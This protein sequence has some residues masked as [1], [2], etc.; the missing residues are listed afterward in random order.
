MAARI[1]AQA[2]KT[3]ARALR[4]RGRRRTE[5]AAQPIF[6]SGARPVLK[7]P[8]VEP[9]LQLLIL[10][11]GPA[12]VLLAGAAVQLSVGRWLRRPG[13]LTGAALFFVAVAG[14]LWL[15]LRFTPDVPVYST[16]WR[17]LLQ[18]GGANLIWIGDGWNWYVSG[19]ILLLGALGILLELN[20]RRSAGRQRRIHAALAVHL[21]VLAG[22]LLFVG[23]ANL[24]TVT[25]TW[26]VLD[27]ISLVR[28]A[29]RG[30]SPGDDS[31]YARG[32]SL[33]GALLLLVALLPAGPTGP[34][35]P[36]QGGS[37]PP[38]SIV[39]LLLAAMIRAGVY[40]FHIWLLPTNRTRVDLAERLLDHMV[41]VL[42]GLWLLGWAVDL[43]RGL[44][45]MQVEFI[46]L[47]VLALLSS[48]V[49]A[50]TAPD[51]ANHT[52]F[53]LAT[54][55]G[56]AAL[57]GAL[58]FTAGPSA[59]LW[60]TTAFA[61]G[62]ALW[63]VGLRVWDGWGWQIPVSVG[64]LAL[65]GAPF[66]P[67]F[68][69]QPSLSRLLTS[70]ALFLAPFAF[71]VVA[72]GLQ[73]AAM[74]RSWETDLRAAGE[75]G[76]NGQSGNTRSGEARNWAALPAA[77]SDMSQGDIIRLLAACL[78]LGLPLAVAGFFP[79]I[80]AGLAALPDAIPP[81]L[82]APPSVVAEMPVWI[83]LVA[84]LAIGLAL[85]W[86]LPRNLAA[87]ESWPARL[88]RVMRLDWLFDLFWWAANAASGV[89]TNVLRVVEGAGYM[90]WLAVL[91]LFGY[92][93]LR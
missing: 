37:L 11:I 39:L 86:R 82:G 41:P 74:L 10:P 68:L 16:P 38:E 58:A 49:T 90:G 66:T 51:R 44:V 89:L 12:L 21:S 46:S 25:L 23:S 91:L 31:G 59:L 26:V 17:P 64:A 24:L 85:V 20:D 83:V 7:L 27:M 28:S 34:A 19:L 56:L 80:M 29:A 61:L 6:W 81:L 48:A 32:F 22:G 52:A 13:W 72:Q 35:Q 4:R 76:G 78:A 77:E 5:G 14:W 33:I 79:G 60:P 53:V 15:L 3:R 50:W 2:E 92:L 65:A 55:A 93:L 73:I 84:P 67:G 36:L 57:A 69:T 87:K 40:P 9:L 71:Y 8:V 88:H 42:S 30:D 18:S 43:G 70:G 45:L 63:L 47:L 54:S 75:Q 1:I 62:G